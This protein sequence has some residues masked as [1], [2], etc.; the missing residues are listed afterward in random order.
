MRRSAS[1]SEADGCKMRGKDLSAVKDETKSLTSKGR[2]QSRQRRRSSHRRRSMRSPGESSSRHSREE[3]DDVG[4]TVERHHRSRQRRKDSSRSRRSS[5]SRDGESRSRRRHRRRSAERCSSGDFLK[6][7]NANCTLPP[8]KQRVSWQ[9]DMVVDHASPEAYQ[10]GNW[11]QR[12]RCQLGSVD[13]GPGDSSATSV[14]SSEDEDEVDPDWA[15]WVSRAPSSPRP[16]PLRCG[17]LNGS[18]GTDSAGHTV[19]IG[20]SDMESFY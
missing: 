5:H 12:V 1:F 3:R 2:L 15:Q 19:L 18:Q 14:S 6:V 16:V 11:K 17:D 9:R 8:T 13:S 7:D 4:T 20:V 10:Q